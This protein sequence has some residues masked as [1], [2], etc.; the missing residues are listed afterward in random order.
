MLS[1]G[2]LPAHAQIIT[3]D[4]KNGDR[5][6]GRLVSE[7]LMGVVLSNALV[8]EITVPSTEILK[9]SEPSRPATNQVA[10]VVTNSVSPQ[11]T[12][13]LAVAK[14]AAK[15][16]LLFNTATWK[17]WHG[18]FLVGA[19]LTFSERNRQVYNARTK[20]IYAKERFK[21]G[22]DY[23]ATY[24]RS[25][26]EQGG[27]QFNKT[28]AN[29]MNGSGKADYDVT[30]KWYVY[31]MGGMGYDEIRLI[32]LR[33]ELGSGLGY[34]LYR[35]ANF[36]ANLEGGAS[37]QKEDR[38]DGTTLS[39][40]F[41]RFGQNAMWKITPNLTLDEKFEYLPRMEDPGEFKFRLEA[42]LRYAIMANVFLN[43][44]LLDMYDSQTANG[45][46]QNDFQLR[47]S[48]GVKF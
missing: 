30:T 45:V 5:L 6:T 23:D 40:F 33:S 28:D 41:V 14:P 7:T 22:L 36:M 9:R 31:A 19:D 38:A 43:L 20:L 37:Y 34:H 13:A 17:N 8:R 44:S 26:I 2:G 12:N 39:T 29:R 25:T 21:G 48:V 46:T 35:S 4:L 42:N 16:N 15:T 47:S 18:E 3:L 24:G 11:A 10:G 1:L 27:R 32:D